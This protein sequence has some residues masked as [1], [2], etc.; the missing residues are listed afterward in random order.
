MNI[1]WIGAI[2]VILGCG[3]MGFSMAATYRREER[4]LRTL[5]RG[6][7]YMT[8]ELQFRLPSL[9]QLTRQT[10]EECGGMIGQA[11]AGLAEALDS[12]TCPDVES[13]M[14]SAL[15]QVKDMPTVALEALSLLGKSLGRFDLDGQLQGLEQVRAYCRRGLSDLENGRDQ[16]IRGYQTLGVC[17]GAALAILL[18]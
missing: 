14:R 11:M 6:L 18:V 15:D 12:Q 16:R 4:I 3:G 5:I 2:L 9:P 1:K 13:C 10:G 8:C 17:T 7:D